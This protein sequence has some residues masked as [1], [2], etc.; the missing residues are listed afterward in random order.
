MDSAK[1]ELGKRIYNGKAKLDTA[2]GAPMAMQETRLRALESRLPEKEQK[3]AN[4]PSYAGKLTP[5]QLDALE[6]YV[7]HRFPKK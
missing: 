3:S 2:T 1:Y 7:A 5:E 6:Y 4:L